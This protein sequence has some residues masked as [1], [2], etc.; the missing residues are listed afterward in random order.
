MQIARRRVY[1]LFGFIVF[2][3][4]IAIAASAQ[5]TI[6][7]PADVPDIQD[8]IF[9]ANNGD[10]ILVSPGT[11][12][13]AFSFQGKNI[14][15]QSTDGPAVTTIDGLFSS[16]AVVFNNGEGP[17]AVLRGFTV[18]HGFGFPEGG[19]I[20]IVNASPTIDG[21]IITNN[22]SCAGAGIS[23]NGGSAVIKNNTISN[24]STSGCSPAQ[25]GAGVRIVNAGNVQ[26]LNN[27]ITGN[28]ET[29][30]G[31]GGGVMIDVGATPLVS[32]NLIQNNSANAFGGGLSV[33]SAAQLVNNVIT[34]NSAGVGGGIY[35]LLNQAQP[36]FVNNTVAGNSAPQGTQ[37]FID[38]FDADV[39]IANNLLIDFTGTGSVFCGSS[40]G[41]IPAFDHD[42][43]FSVTPAGGEVAAYGGAC[44]DATGTS[45]NIQ[46]DPLFS[47]IAIGDYHL[48]S[49][50]PAL[51]AGN[52][53]APSLPSTDLDGSSRIAAGNT[54]SC[55]GV[56]DMGAYELVAPSTGT[57]FLNVQSLDFGTASIG[58]GPG[59][60]QSV[61]F[62][63]NQGCVQ[64]AVQIRGSDFQQTSD[65]TALQGGNSCTIQVTFNPVAPGLRTG[66]L[67]VNLGPGTTAVTAGLKGQALNSVSASPSSLD[68]GGQIVGSFATS[69]LVNI[70]PNVNA[71]L[72]ISNVSITGTD[73]SQFSAC[74]QFPGSCSIQVI[75]SPTAAGLRT[76]VLT[77]TSNLGIV[78]VPL[79]GSGLSPIASI[80]PAAL[81]FPSQVVNTQSQ[82]QTVTLTNSGPIDLLINGFNTSTFDYIVQPVDCFGTLARGASCT[83]SVIFLPENIGDI[84]ATLEVDTNG[85]NVTVALDGSGTPPIATLSPQM[86]TFPAGTIGSASA[87][88]TVTVTNISGAPLQITSIGADNNFFAFST[89]PSILDVNAS[90]SIDVSFIPNN[91]GPY[92]G[93]LSFT[94]NLGTVTAVLSTQDAHKTLH[95]PADFPT[96]SAAIS[97]ANNGDTVLVSPGTYF[98][99]IDFQ[100]KAI[101]VVSASGPALTVIDGQNS[102]TPVIMQNNEPPQA[103]LKGFTITHGSNGAIQLSSASPTIEDNVVTNNTGCGDV[104]TG[105]FAAFSAAVIRHNTISRNTNTCIGARGGTVLFMGPASLGRAQMVDNNIT[106]NQDTTDG[107]GGISVWDGNVLIQGNTIEDNSTTGSGGGIFVTARSSVDI[108]QNLIAGNSAAIGG[109]IYEFIDNPSQSPLFLSNTIANNSSASPGTAVFIEG[110]DANVTITNNIL[111]DS[112]GLPAIACGPTFGQSPMFASDDVVSLVPNT[113]AYGGI[114]Q[115]PTGIGRNIKQDPRF[116]NAAGNN[117]HLQPSSPAIDA[118]FIADN[119]PTQDFDGNG[120]VGPGNAQSCLNSIDMG[121]YE[122]Q[123]ASSGNSNLPTNNI[124][125]GQVPVSG[126]GF[127]NL[128]AGA[129]GC[130][131]L[132]SIKTTGDFQQTNSCGGALDSSS[133]CSIQLTFIPTGTGPRTGSL[134]LDFGASAP[135][136][137]VALTGTGFLASQATSPASLTFGE[138]AVGTSSTPLTFTLFPN[139]FGVSFASGEV[140][141]IWISGDF[142]QTNTCTGPNSS[143]VSSSGCT[144]SVTF[145]PTATGPRTGSL[146]IST[147]QGMATVPLSGDGITPLSASLTP[148]ALVFPDQLVNTVSPAQAVTLTNTGSNSFVPETLPAS[149]DITVDTS[150]CHT[151]LAPGASCTYLISF[152]PSA[153]GPRRALFEVEIST[154]IFTVDVSG[155]GIGPATSLSPQLL[156]FGKQI[157][158]TTSAAQALI[159][160]NSGNANLNLSGITSSGD[161]AQTNNCIA[162][163]APGGSCVINATFTPTAPGSR[164]G[165]LIINS[166]AG[167]I[168]VPLSGAGVSAVAT[169][170]PASVSLGSEMTGSTTSPQ[171]VILTAGINPLQISSIAAS[172]DFA[173]TNAC[174]VLLAAGA[175]CAIQ[176]T[177][178]PTIQGA[179]SGSLTITSNEGT[180]S[181]PLSGS[182]ITRAANTI[183]VPVD[184]PTIQAGISAASTG[185]TVSVFPGTYKEHISFLGKAITVTSTDGPAA[186][187]I[188][189]GL[190]GTVATFSTGEGTS[191]V[192]SGFTI[193]RGTST[194]EG[195]G[196]L[197]SSASPTI[198]NN[199]ITFNQGCQGVG[200]AVGFGSPIIQ[201]NTISHNTETTCSGGDGAGISLRGAGTPQ[202]LNNIITDNT[203]SPGG[204]GGAIASNAA[205]PTISGNIIQRN[206]VFNDGG[207]ISIFNSADATI[208][209]NLITDNHA[210]GNGGGIF[211]G[212]PSGDRGPIA[213]NNTI[214][215]NTATNGSA[216]YSQGFVANVQIYNNILVGSNGVPALDCDGTFSSTSPILANN[217]AFFS[218]AS[219]FAGTC[220]TASG[221]NGNVSVDPQF[222]DSFGGNYH[223]QATSPVID[224]GN[225]AAPN[226]PV[227]DL[228]GNPRIAF[229]SASTCS[230]TVDLGAYEFVLVTTPAAT[231]SPA[232]LDFG[233]QPVGTTSASQQFTLTATQGCVS[234][235]SITTSGDFTQ[236]N[237]CSSPLG[238]GNSC[239][240]QVSFAPTV[241]GSRTGSLSITANGSPLASS[242][243]GQGGFASTSFSPVSVSFGNQRVQT[244]SAAQTVTLTNAGNIGLQ[245]SGIS[246]SGPFSQSNTCPA[247]LAAG[248][249]CTMSVTFA[250]VA[251]R[252]AS[253][254]LTLSSNNSSSPDNVPLTGTGIAPIA[255]LTPS[256]TFGAQ[257]VGTTS[258]QVATLTNNGNAPLNISG[259][260]TSGDFTAFSAC[261][262]ALAPQT[263]CSVQ[264]SFTPSAAGARTGSLVI[265]DDDPAGPQQIT[266]LTGTGLDFSVSA[267]PSSVS[268][269]AGSAAVYTATVTGLGGNFATSV[270]LACSG[271]PTGASCAFSPTS[272]VP[273]AGSAPSTLNLATSSGQ[274]GTKKTPA[275]TYTI[276]IRGTSGQLIRSTTATLV[277]Q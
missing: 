85:G 136:Q 67:S 162:T 183:Y 156:S 130:V 132:S 93:F 144:F 82:P 263:S 76:G 105:I 139:F 158:N 187:T 96:I 30:G 262:A 48:Q 197:I 60:P 230:D 201:N 16:S 259:V 250:P 142:S 5:N 272:V 234:A 218:G 89:C 101:T 55:L 118:G 98:E 46:A 203:I 241:R 122:F 79:S 18:T 114:C 111:V 264:V 208:T 120:R 20:Q 54:T 92:N 238:T 237:N 36:S 233:I 47:A 271:L 73:F 19:G 174:G 100:G 220:A 12:F 34:G 160:T 256:L 41:Q 189:G 112:A 248:T 273:G 1:N 4:S 161:F 108:V 268:V 69:Q 64:A 127:F 170:N 10:T 68:F 61:T 74:T 164:S 153:S 159:L 116:V 206:S 83:Y 242:L 225:N 200:I 81:V 66:V 204:D 65:C 181:V 135:A 219:G 179:E 29:N 235:S 78:T 229:G 155:T 249:S 50:S 28:Q 232:S 192:L 178:T 222:V 13:G 124:D 17:G 9:A 157:L 209:Q 210:T 94:T 86:L 165:S 258:S 97:A 177:F 274:H 51:D 95:V 99:H 45:G 149:G 246:I 113:P 42:D 21:N 168:G 226:L 175:S 91:F 214:A 216:I 44:T 75:F 38:G 190:T 140:N 202:I 266:S 14:A 254:A 58:A 217:D 8:A 26:L 198:S 125:F 267:S 43:V 223:L 129:L 80:A 193:T 84:S 171:T 211:W 163:I 53:S 33:N 70:S 56:V 180:L 245:I 184:Q 243:S 154:L 255:V 215:G 126:S 59:F 261:P 123:I 199:V 22:Q 6:H 102:F 247:T 107:G 35:S 205:S 15:I 72:Q 252:A 195:G 11:Y 231:L 141:G 104:A 244:T 32:G 277:V 188:D 228:D 227:M 276:T 191:S 196:I 71:P 182:A 270:S 3:L 133:S 131:Q 150:Q 40:S 145:T 63:A 134:K 172:G 260:I 185:Q 2:L 240:I 167:N 115:D 146:V 88:Q 265:T 138:Q 87:A 110:N 57:G 236:T 169:T 52:N 275:G 269:K 147:S 253:G 37:L 207:G 176:I 173:Q 251:I 7:V 106:G 239:A 62:F 213:V 121:V 90:C 77:V 152:V 23:S 31:N 148:S 186:T 117:Y 119:E 27:T 221:T 143:G 24:N 39:E 151:A 128:F 212:V 194:F 103:V 257:N 224:A 49:A 166:N 25:G 137:T 109:G